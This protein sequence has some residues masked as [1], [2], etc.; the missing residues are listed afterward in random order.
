MADSDE[1]G[2][3]PQ[4]LSQLAR[5]YVLAGKS[6][7]AQQTMAKLNQLSKRT[8][9]SPYDRAT[10]DVALGQ[11]DRALTELEHAYQKQDDRMIWLGTDL[12]FEGLHSEPRFQALLRR[13]NFPQ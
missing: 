9:V 11:K 6:A 1:N 12:R 10:I 7:E 13:M 2:T 3:D 5:A 4:S 8:Y